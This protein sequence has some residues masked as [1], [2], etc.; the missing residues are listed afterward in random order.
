MTTPM[1]TLREEHRIILRALDAL[2]SAAERLAAGRALPPGWWQALIEWL[3]AFA[4]RNHHA[5]EEQGLFPAMI[6][7][8]VPADGGPVAVMLEEHARGRALL[9]AMAAG[10]PEARASNARLYV[11]LLRGHIEKE[12][13][14]VFPLAD[15]VLDDRAQRELGR[16]FDSVAADGG[17]D[18]APERAEASIDRLA[19]SLVT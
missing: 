17:A 2:E 7:A 15:A 16:A 8:G 19:A 18:V 11:E 12:N 13:G 1:E 3:R 9:Q 4:D 10:E 6:D 5:K 14:I